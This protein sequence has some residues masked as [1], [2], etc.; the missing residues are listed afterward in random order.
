MLELVVGRAVLI[1][2][3]YSLN[4]C[5]DGSLAG[6]NDESILIETRMIP[7]SN[8]RSASNHSLRGA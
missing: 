4:V 3:A 1:K 7:T 2:K 5:K 8:T 6:Q